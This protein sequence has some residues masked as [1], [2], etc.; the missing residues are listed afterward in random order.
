MAQPMENPTLADIARHTG[1]S[2]MTVSRTVRGLGRI[3]AST[4]ERVLAAANELGYR[5]NHAARATAVGRFNAV[6]IVFSTS[7]R[8]SSLPRFVLD[9]I[10]DELARHRLHPNFAIVP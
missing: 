5:P 7:A 1:V 9:G 4:R 8:R 2:L 10:H 6:T 3:S